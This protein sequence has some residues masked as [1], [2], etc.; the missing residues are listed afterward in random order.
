ME[1]MSSFLNK[2]AFAVLVIFLLK[3]TFIDD[4]RSQKQQRSVAQDQV[5]NSN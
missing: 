4:M 1:F 2:M 3:I 5:L